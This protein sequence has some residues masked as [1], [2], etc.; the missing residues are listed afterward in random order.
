MLYHRKTQNYQNCSKFVLKFQ[1]W[2][3]IL[4]VYGVGPGF[5]ECGLVN[6]LF[7]LRKWINIKSPYITIFNHPLNQPH[8][9]VWASR[10][11]QNERAMCHHWF[12][13]TM[14]LVYCASVPPVPECD[15]ECASVPEGHPEVSV[16]PLDIS[17]RSQMSWRPRCCATVPDGS[18]SFT[19]L[20]SWFGLFACNDDIW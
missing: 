10:V 6:C 3:L 2:V 5:S 20:Y 8:H 16:L 19:R 18:S 11:S 15:R 1:I 14:G 17:Q 4:S 13:C 9:L 12:A 7:W